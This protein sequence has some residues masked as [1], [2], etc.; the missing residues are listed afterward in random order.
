MSK[1][2]ADIAIRVFPF[3]GLKEDWIPWEA[4]FLARAQKLGYKQYVIEDHNI[5]SAEEAET[6]KEGEET[7]VLTDDE[8]KELKSYRANT[9]AFA[10]L[11]MSM[12][13][14][15]AGGLTAFHMVRSTQ[16]D[17]KYPEGHAYRA[18][19][20]LKKNIRQRLRRR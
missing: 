9:N 18:F 8:M 3:S 7:N 20:K 10:D 16:Q 12:N 1:A 17:K 15:N 19:T 14:Q 4:K 6:L 11:I 5:I 2:S 13:T